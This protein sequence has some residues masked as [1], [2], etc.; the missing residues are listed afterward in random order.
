VDEIKPG[1]KPNWDPNFFGNLQKGKFYKSKNEFSELQPKF[2][3]IKKI[4][5]FFKKLKNKTWK[6]KFLSKPRNKQH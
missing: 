6:R 5:I 2:F 3:Q 1:F 4:P